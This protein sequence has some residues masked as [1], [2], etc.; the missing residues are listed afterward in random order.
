MP[1]QGAAAGVTVIVP[2]YNEE[3]SIGPV[4]GQIKEV[5]GGAG[6]PYQLLVVDDGST[7]RT[8]EISQSKGAEVVRHPTNRGYGA[9]VKAGCRRA[10][11][12]TI[13]ITD[14]DGTYPNDQIPHLVSLMADY[15]MVVG[16]RTGKEVHVPLIRR[17][18]KWLINTLA[19]WFTRTRIPD[20][21]SGLRALRRELVLR[22]YPVLPDGFSFTTTITLAML[23]NGYLVQYVPIDYHRR[24]GQSKIRP[25]RD[26]LNFTLLIIRT[27]V[28]YAPLRVFLPLAGLLLFA[29]VAVGLYSLLVLDRFMDATTIVLVLAALQIAAAGL[30]AD[31]V[32]KRTPRF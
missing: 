14:A 10:R 22:F 26:T 28:Y 27:T 30:L 15:D 19:N 32:D 31:M 6:I 24:V 18:A 4:L 16:A 17:P 13:V 9:A 29:G 21:N 3:E 7:D 20:L 8:V 1:S 2:A 12:E 23:A 5:L 25:V 11:H